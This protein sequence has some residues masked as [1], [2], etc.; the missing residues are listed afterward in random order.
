MRNPDVGSAYPE[1]WAVVLWWVC[2]G[3]VG[4]QLFKLFVLN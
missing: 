2:L 4:W 1:P 3:I